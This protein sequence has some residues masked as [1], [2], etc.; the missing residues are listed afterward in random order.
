MNAKRA[1]WAYLWMTVVFIT[2]S[3]LVSFMLRDPGIGMLAFLSELSLLLPALIL[4][5]KGRVQLSRQLHLKGIRISTALMTLV[6]HLCCYPLI[7][8]MNSFTMAISDNASMDITEQ[9]GDVSF[10]A[11]FFFVGLLGPLVEELVFRGILLGGLRTTGRIFSAIL[12]SALLFALAH[13]NINQFSYTICAGVFWG[14]LVEASGSLIPSIICHICMNGVSVMAVYLFDKTGELDSMV[15][16]GGFDSPLGYIFTGFIF[17]FISIFTTALAMLMLKV[18]SINEGR[19]GCF[20]NIF[21]RKLKAER[22]GS[23][24]SAPMITGICISAVIT[25]IAFIIEFIGRF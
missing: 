24:M 18:I 14:L 11:M 22:F 3:I 20:E 19:T 9:F 5:S 13:M 17:L 8:A 10:A 12:L 15:D 2:F 4:L 23:L 1:G 25:V 16:S 6:Y 21:R 7:I